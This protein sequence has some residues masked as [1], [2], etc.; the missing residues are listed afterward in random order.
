MIE[1]HHHP[2]EAIGGN[3]F[4]VVLGDVRAD[5]LNTLGSL[6][7]H[8]HAA[9]VLSELVPVKVR[10]FAGEGGIGLVDSGL[11]DV[12]VHQAGLEVE[13]EGGAISDR[14]LEAVAAHVAARVLLCTEGVIGVA[15]D[16]VD[17]SAG[18]AK[19]K[20]IGKSAA[21]LH[22]ETSLLG[23]VRFVDE[24]DD[25][26]AI[27][28]HPFCFPEAED[29]GDDDLAGVLLE[30]T[31][32]IGAGFALHQVGHIAGMEGA[33]DLGIEVDAVDHDHHGGVAEHGMLAEL[34]GRKHHQQR[35]A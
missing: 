34:L 19:Q 1:G 24:H 26:V 28:E 32:Q 17:G 3:G 30:Q 5:A 2:L 13:L 7:Q 4:L 31:H 6:Y 22:A 10:Q 20:G 29:G 8:G 23:A 25:V 12:Q 35:L 16:P 33:T 18:E 11:V 9:G 15:I 27:V 14:L 21:H